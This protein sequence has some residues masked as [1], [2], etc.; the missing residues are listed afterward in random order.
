MAFLPLFC[1]ATVAGDDYASLRDQ[2]DAQVAAQRFAEAEKLGRRMLAAA[3]RSL[4]DQPRNAAVALNKMALLYNRLGRHDDAIGCYKRSLAILE[5]LHGPE[6]ADVASSLNNLAYTYNGQGKYAEAEAARKWALAIREKTLGPD[7]ADTA[8]S[9]D[10]QA[11][12]YDNTV[13][14]RG[15]TALQAGPG[16]PRKDPGARP[17]RYGLQPQQPGLIRLRPGTLRRSERFDGR[18]LAIRKKALGLNHVD[19][20]SSLN[21]LACL[22]HDQARYADQNL[23]QV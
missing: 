16:D 21:N 8:I 12:L 3:E 9:V 20:A 2:F 17:R 7:H 5:A 4:E 13:L 1:Q 23:R 15:G 10:N 6:H 11:C 22:Y 14:C 18:A 19:T